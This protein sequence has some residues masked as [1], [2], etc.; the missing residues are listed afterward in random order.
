MPFLRPT[1]TELRGQAMNDIAA[2][3]LPAAD[4]L[5]RRSVLR[6]LAWVQAGLAHLHYGYLDWI[7]RMAVPF[8][9]LEEFL[10]AWANLI[11]I[12]RKPATQATGQVS[13]TGTPATLIPLGTEVVRSDGARFHTLADATVAGDGTV[14]VDVLA[15]DAGVGGQTDADAQFV[16]GASIAGVN[17]GGVAV[18]AFTGGA[19]EETDESLR[20][21]MLARFAEPPQGGSRAD[22]LL[23][24]TAV[25]G[26]TRAWVV[27]SQL[28]AGTVSVY[29]MLD[30]AQ[31]AYDGFPQ[32][33]DGVAT[34]ETRDEPATGDQ[35]AVANAIYPLQPVTALVYVLAPIAYPVAVQIEDLDQDTAIIRADI[36]AALEAMLLDKGE[37]GGTLYPSD[38]QTA[39]AAV[40]GVNRFTL[41]APSDGVEMPAGNLPTLGTITYA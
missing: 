23:W 17:T 37:V 32:G 14:T 28:G 36:S 29:V 19:A 2:S 21:R 15:L 41:V 40:A 16:L 5:L 27:G 38:F 10:V 24:A 8:T 6:V 22:Y 39:I 13:F 31:A 35:L 26:V 25:P 30:D 33:D 11:G 34:D 18:A 4:G 20:S 9:A 3:D 7:A 1:L 12:F